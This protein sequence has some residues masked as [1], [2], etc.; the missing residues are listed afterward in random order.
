MHFCRDWRFVFMS[1]SLELCWQNKSSVM[2][3]NLK[4]IQRPIQTLTTNV[5]SNV[6]NFGHL[7]TLFA[8]ADRKKVQSKELYTE[9]TQHTVVHTHTNL[10]VSSFC[11]RHAWREFETPPPWPKLGTMV[12]T[13]ATRPPRHLCNKQSGLLD[14]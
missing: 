2:T 1:L 11:A 14:V 12:L 3:T 8:S 7:F 10:R 5:N 9:K 6:P 13:L 4:K